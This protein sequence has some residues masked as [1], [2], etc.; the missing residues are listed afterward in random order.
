[1][2]AEAPTPTPGPLP[3]QD[4]RL[5]VRFSWRHRSAAARTFRLGFAPGAAVAAPCRADGFEAGDKLLHGVCETRAGGGDVDAVIVEVSWRAP[6]QAQRLREDP[7]RQPDLPLLTVLTAAEGTGGFSVSRGQLARHP[8]MWLPAH[9]VFLTPAEAPVDFAAHLGSLS[10]QRVLDRVA[11]APEAS[12][13]E[14]TNK[15]TDFGN[16]TQPHEGQETSWLGTRGHLVGTV[17]R[18]G[19][20]YKFGVD[21]WANVRPDHASPHQFRFDLLWPGCA[22]AGQEIVEGLPVIVTRLQRAG[23]RAAIEQWAAPLRDLPPARRGELASV[24]CTHI[25]LSGAAGPVSLGFRLATQTTNRH[26]EL[27][28]VAGQSCVVDRETGAVWLMVEPSAGLT[29]QP[30][31]PKYAA[32]YQTQQKPDG[33]VGGYAEWGVYSPGMLYAIGQNALLSGDRAS[34]ER[35]LPA[36]LRPMDWC[37]QEVAQG[38]SWADAPGLIVAPLN[39]LTHAK[40]AWAFPNAYFVAGLNIF[41][42]ALAACGHPRAAEVQ[43]AAAK[44]RADVT[45]AFAR[46]SVRAPVVPLADGT[47]NNYVPCDALTPRRQL[48]EWYPTDVDCGPLH[49]ARLAAIDPRGWLATAMLHDHEDNLF[50]HQWG[51]ANEPVYNPQATAYLYR[52]EPEAAIRAF[53]SMLASASPSLAPRPTSAPSASGSSAPRRAAPSPP[54]WNSS[55]DAAPRPCLCA[56]GTRNR[57]LRGRSW[58][59]AGTRLTSAPP[60]NG[61][62]FPTPA[63]GATPSSPVTDRPPHQGHHAGPFLGRG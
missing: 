6:G 25:R 40:R 41:G 9:D 38:Q 26:P 42:R 19:S 21:R 28:E 10:D 24:F 59:T 56:S 35:L 47:W 29:L 52:D 2:N 20:L 17:A 61:S 62:A 15:W 46:A 34:F 12:L 51:M 31:A 60:R 16:P 50:L 5:Q 4:H 54:R 27:R 39:D 32:I 58:S 11:R 22:W 37:L 3:G 18:H 63:R 44:M 53:Y 23:Q 48:E 57:S 45:T 7:G 13:A 55:A 33:R 49:L 43:A 8:T 36:S 14:W 30:R 1:M